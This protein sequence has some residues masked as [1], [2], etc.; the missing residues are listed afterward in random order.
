LRTGGWWRGC[1]A[2]LPPPSAN[3]DP[4]SHE[5]YQYFLSGKVNGVVDRNYVD[6]AGDPLSFSKLTM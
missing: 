3:D 4:K 6:N 5:A 1:E 2:P